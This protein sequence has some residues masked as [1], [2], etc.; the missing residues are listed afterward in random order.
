MQ[1]GFDLVVE[2][3]PSDEVLASNAGKTAKKFQKKIVNA[4]KV[5]TQATKKAKET[6]ESEARVQFNSVETKENLST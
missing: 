5:V 6:I 4:K 3:M 1:S 2:D